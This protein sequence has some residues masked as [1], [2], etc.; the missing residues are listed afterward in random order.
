MRYISVHISREIDAPSQR[1][2]IKFI[3][4]KISVFYPSSCVFSSRMK[5]PGA[6]ADILFESRDHMSHQV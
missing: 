1:D 5:Q 3:P 6:D 2:I 4:Y